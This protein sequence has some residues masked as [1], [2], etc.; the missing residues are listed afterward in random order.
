MGCTAALMVI[1]LNNVTTFDTALAKEYTIKPFMNR[2]VAIVKDAPLFFYKSEDYPVMFYA[3]RHIHRYQP[4]L[5]TVS[6][7]FYV[8]FWEKEWRPIRKNEGLSVRT[9]SQSTDRTD[10][11]RGHLLLVEVKTLDALPSSA[12]PSLNSAEK[13]QNL[14]RASK[15]KFP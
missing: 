14:D 10:P 15:V 8:L 7:P 13:S 3:G 12:Q 2:V 4:P 11:E 9:T 6:S 5:K 1:S